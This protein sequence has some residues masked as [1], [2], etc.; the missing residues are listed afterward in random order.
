MIHVQNLKKTYTTYERGHSFM[1]A[2]ISVF[3]RK[4]IEVQAVKGL[5]FHVKA[6]EIVGFLGPN[7]AGKST[8]LKMLTGVLHPTSGEVKIMNFTPWKHRKK[9][10]ANIGAVFGQKSQL[11]WDIPPIDAFY[12]NK[13]IY[14]I[15][16]APFNETLDQ[17]VK[18][19]D[20]GQIIRKPTRQLSL[21]ERMKCEFIM[22]MLHRPFVVFLDEP[23]IGLDVIAK[24]KIREFILEM[25]NRGVTFIL[26]T[27]DLED[28]DKLA[29]R[30]IVVNHGEIVFDDSITAL[31]NFLGAKKTLRLTTEQPADWD[32]FEGVEVISRESDLEAELELDTEKLPLKDFIR[33]MNERYSIHDM[34]IE[35]LPIERVIKVLY[36]TKA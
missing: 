5:T 34:S 33:L 29:R 28:V 8:T 6:G 36:E 19:L 25:N 23:T 31:R 15:E 1:E 7:G 14:N 20:V 22:A 12:M 18:L 3:K 30:V 24:E 9:Y 2:I 26:T 35:A 17:L 27:H 10:V 32:S 16:D 21:G 4:T 13:A 11:L